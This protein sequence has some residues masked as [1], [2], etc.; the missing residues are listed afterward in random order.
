MVKKKTQI[1]WPIFNY[2]IK[3]EE[4]EYRLDIISKET[5]LEKKTENISKTNIDNYDLSEDLRVESK[6]NNF[7]KWLSYNNFSCR[8]DCFFLIFTFIITNKIANIKDKIFNNYIEFYNTISEE[9][10]FGTILNSIK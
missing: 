6:D 4:E 7:R 2:F 9:H 1:T 8:F 10:Q 3:E 5:K